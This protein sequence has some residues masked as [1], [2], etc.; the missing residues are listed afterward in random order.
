MKTGSYIIL[1][2]IGVIAVAGGIYLFLQWAQLEEQLQQQIGTTTFES[3][4]N[5]KR[6]AD[7]NDFSN[8][9]TLVE[10]TVGDTSGYGAGFG[11]TRTMAL[12]DGAMEVNAIDESAKGAPQVDR[13]SETNVQVQDIDEPDIVK[14]NGEEIFLSLEQW[15]YPW[16]GVDDVRFEEIPVTS[17]SSVD[18]DSSSEE[19]GAADDSGDSS[20]GSAG[21]ATGDE[22]APEDAKIAA[23]DFYEPQNNVSVVKALPPEAMEKLS[24]IDTTGDLLLS[25][26]VLVAIGYEGIK[27]FDI[28]DPAQPT[29]KWSYDFENDSYY[30]TARLYG[31]TIYLVLQT[32]LDY[33]SPCPVRPLSDGEMYTV[34][35]ADIY[36]PGAP[37][38]TEL[39]STILSIDAPS[40]FIN[41][42]VTF[43]GSYDQSVI[44]MS[45][46]NL[47]ATYAY[48]A[49]TYVMM[50][51]FFT[52]DG[53]D[54]FPAATIDRL[55]AVNGY[56]ISVEAKMVELEQTLTKYMETLSDDDALTFETNIEDRLDKFYDNH[57]REFERTDITKIGTDSFEVAATGS[58]PGHPLNQF[59]LDEYNNHLRIATTIGES[60]WFGITA[61]TL[62]D[63]YVLDSNLKQT[64]SVMDLGEGE[65]IY[66]TRFI[67]DVGYMVTFRE[68][69]PFYVFDLSNP[70]APKKTGELKIPGYSA[71]LHPIS[72]DRVLG[73]G[74]EDQQVK[75]SLF[76]VSDPSNP[77]EKD[78]YQLNEYWSDILDTHHAFLLDEKY[79]VFFLPGSNGGYVL[80]YENDKLEL[81]KA[82]SDIQAKRALYI[83]DYLYIL[84]SDKIVVLSEKDWE[85]A[86]QLKLFE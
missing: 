75:V 8:Y 71:Y 15:Y 19:P 52:T 66:S 23:P 69:D 45:K 46:D 11:S 9:L 16:Y 64:G 41:D 84:G 44:Y 86:G 63:L 26:D 14:T 80:S 27:G 5:F 38:R 3:N 81:K 74:R 31:N 76:D 56:D 10:E 61:N 35:C 22:D 12:E 43:T 18:E 48:T 29:E 53:A 42:S 67:G 50:Y 4:F 13:V 28:S 83:N 39:T 49:P 82:V 51:G 73:I 20:E 77:T 32:P 33:G 70:N 47:Y 85:R 2:V 78:K 1:A 57:L 34:A 6:F 59:S 17:T 40:G 36:Y 54:L 72:E 30:D 58:V 62:N 60:F 55:K 25:G 7:E 79:S 24:T 37:V 21:A 68:T 65:R